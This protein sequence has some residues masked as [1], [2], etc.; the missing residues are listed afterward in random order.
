MIDPMKDP[1][2]LREESLKDL[3]PRD[4]DFIDQFTREYKE[5]LKWPKDR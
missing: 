5:Q 3:S 1:K 2:K 4:R